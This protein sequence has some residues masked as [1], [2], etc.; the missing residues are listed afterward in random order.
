MVA[1]SPSIAALPSSSPFV[2]GGRRSSAGSPADL[3]A[4]VK[5]PSMNTSSEVRVPQSRRAVGSPEPA[6]I[7]DYLRALYPSKT[8]EHVAADTGISRETVHT[9]FGRC[10]APSWQHMA[11]L[12][13]TYGP[14]FLAAALPARPAWLDGHVREERR[15]RLEAEI[16]ARQAEL[17]ALRSAP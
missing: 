8:A 11:V 4:R 12:I 9:W 7:L 13:I 1:L 10:S 17:D 15:Q 14:D 3:A 16:T 2:V 6:K 5:R